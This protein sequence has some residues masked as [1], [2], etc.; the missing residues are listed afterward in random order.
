LMSAVPVGP[1]QNIDGDRTQAALMNVS[2][3]GEMAPTESTH[4]LH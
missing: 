4:T 3:I 2:Y 1:V